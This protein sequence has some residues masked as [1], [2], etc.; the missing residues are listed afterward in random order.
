MSV[1][2]NDS[3]RLGKIPCSL[4]LSRTFDFLINKSD[5]RR[6]IAKEDTWEELFRELWYELVRSK[7]RL[8]FG[9]LGC[10]PSFSE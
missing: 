2:A 4:E 5:T 1:F 6:L 7:A 8:M 3:E 10:F 9:E